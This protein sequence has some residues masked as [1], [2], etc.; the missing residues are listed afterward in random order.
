[1]Y[2][3]RII[4]V[5]FLL[6]R[7]SVGVIFLV[8]VIEIVDRGAWIRCSVDVR[9]MCRR[10]MSRCWCII[11]GVAFT[12]WVAPALFTT[13]WTKLEVPAYN[14]SPDLQFLWH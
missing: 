13:K 2:F 11:R 3:S 12:S 5:A 4:V 9:S 10:Y 14:D 6:Q 8:V 7:V 1:M